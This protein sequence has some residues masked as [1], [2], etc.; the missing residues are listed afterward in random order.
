MRKDDKRRLVCH[1]DSLAASHPPTSAAK[2]PFF[3]FIAC[4]D[5]LIFYWLL[6]VKAEKIMNVSTAVFLDF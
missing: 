2:L 4:I 1:C 3:A 6:L 5:T